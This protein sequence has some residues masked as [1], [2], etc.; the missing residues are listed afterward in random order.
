MKNPYFNLLTN[1]WKFSDN[2]QRRNIVVAGAMFV[3]ANLVE[4]S[5][6]MILAL[7]INEIQKGVDETLFNKI[8]IY[9]LFFAGAT[10][11]FLAFTRSRTS[12]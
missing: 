6:P 1:Y 4:L 5:K 7:M 8:L 3:V 2:K 9:L 12:Y 11:V 10:L